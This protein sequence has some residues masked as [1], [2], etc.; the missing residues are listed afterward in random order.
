MLIGFDWDSMPVCQSAS[1]PV[2]EF[3]LFLAL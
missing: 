2:V 1:A 3:C